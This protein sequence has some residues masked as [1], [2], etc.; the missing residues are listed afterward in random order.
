M[1]SIISGYNKMSKEVYFVVTSF[2][3]KIIDHSGDFLQPL[4]FYIKCSD[5]FPG[6]M[7]CHHV[8]SYKQ[9]ITLTNIK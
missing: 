9:N 1:F 5:Y 8:S 7:T 2:E 4:S 3:Y 6:I